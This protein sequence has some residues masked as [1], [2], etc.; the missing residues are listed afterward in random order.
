M[1]REAHFEVK[2][3]KALQRRTGFGRVWCR[4]SVRRC[5][6]KRI[7]K[8]KCTKHFNAELALGGCDVGKVYANVARSA[9]KSKC[10]KHFSAGSL[11]EVVMLRKWTRLWQE[12]HV[13][14]KVVKQH[15]LGPWV[16]GAV[17]ETCSTEMWGGQA[18]ISWDGLHF[19]PS[20][21]QVCKADL[22]DRCSTSYDLA[23]LFQAR[24]L[25]QLEWKNRKMHW[26]KAVSPALNFPFLKEVLQNCF[27][28]DV[29]NLKNWE[30]SQDSFVFD[31]VKVKKWG[32]LAELLCFWCCQVPN[33]RMSRRRAS[34]WNFRIDR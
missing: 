17:Q 21:L 3:Y 31:V 7:L 11:L 27:I 29:V 30:V 20:A 13:R 33:L 5:G 28:F 4:K 8:S 15:M 1:W 16:A 6:A 23:S 22:R 26:Y 32:S 25:G 10:R 9:L 34:F 14:I 18:L 24:H 19:A 12:A 2:M